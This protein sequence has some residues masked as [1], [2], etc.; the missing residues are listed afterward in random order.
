M[1]SKCAFVFIIHFH[2]YLF[3]SNKFIDSLSK[4]PSKNLIHIKHVLSLMLPTSLDWSSILITYVGKLKT[5]LTSHF[6][7]NM[8]SSFFPSSIFLLSADFDCSIH[9]S[10]VFSLHCTLLLMPLISFLFYHLCLWEFL[11]ESSLI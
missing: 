2:I 10:S 1:I 3:F 4:Y 9:V 8:H 5:S 11:R 7:T 6:V